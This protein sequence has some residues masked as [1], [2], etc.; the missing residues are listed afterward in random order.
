M[1]KVQFILI[2]ALVGASSSLSLGAEDLPGGLPKYCTPP[3]E[4]LDL[5]EAPWTPL[6]SLSPDDRVMALLD[7]PPMVPISELAAPELKLAG[8]RFNPLTAEQTREGYFRKPALMRVGDALEVPVKGIPEGARIHRAR[9]SILHMLCEM[10]QYLE[11]YV[12]NAR[13]PQ[14]QVGVTQEPP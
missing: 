10:D 1:R 8:L 14:T 13:R 11:K 3:K 6:V 4:I 9:E 12:K 5:A 7:I 2:M